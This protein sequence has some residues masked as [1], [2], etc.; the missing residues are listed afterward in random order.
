MF[1]TL[2]V[3]FVFII[4]LGISLALYSFVQ[5]GNVEDALSQQAAKKA[6]VLATKATNVPELDCSRIG[7]TRTKCVDLL[8]L[9]SINYVLNSSRAAREYYFDVFQTARIVIYQLWPQSNMSVTLYDNLDTRATDVLYEPLLLYNPL[10]E[11]NTFGM[12]EIR[13]PTT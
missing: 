8:K 11:T 12:M 1:E 2:G 9:Q 3:L 4:L 7:F 10:T 13:V 5:Q 6:T